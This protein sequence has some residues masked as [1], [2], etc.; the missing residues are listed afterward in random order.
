MDRILVGSAPRTI[1]ANKKISAT[2]H[3]VVAK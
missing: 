2:N 3:L 1:F